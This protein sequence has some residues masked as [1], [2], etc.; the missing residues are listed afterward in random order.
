MLKMASVTVQRQSRQDRRWLLCGSGKCSIDKER[1]WESMYVYV[2]QREV[3][4]SSNSKEKVRASFLLL[5]FTIK[6]DGI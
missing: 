5:F 2:W 4:N 1:T 3:C 6:D